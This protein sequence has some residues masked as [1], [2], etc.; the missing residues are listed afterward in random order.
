MNFQHRKIVSNKSNSFSNT[1]VLEHT[2]GF[3]NLTMGKGRNLTQSYE[4]V[5]TPIKKFKKAK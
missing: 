2:V 5:L 1:H 4:K 3:C